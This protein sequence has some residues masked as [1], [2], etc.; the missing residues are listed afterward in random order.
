[1]RAVSRKGVQLKIRPTVTAPRRRFSPRARPA[2]SAE[3]PIAK[4]IGFLN[5]LNRMTL[6]TRAVT[7]IAARTAMKIGVE[8]TQTPF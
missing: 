1:L 4:P 7:K 6:A 3:A 2:G 5:P 8:R